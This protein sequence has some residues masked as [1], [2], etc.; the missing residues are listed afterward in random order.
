MHNA[1]NKIQLT[2]WS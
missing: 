2:S 1:V